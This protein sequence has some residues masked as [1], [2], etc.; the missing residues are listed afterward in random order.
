MAMDVCVCESIFTYAPTSCCTE[1][2]RANQL[3]N[4]CLHCSSKEVANLAV[5]KGP[6]NQRSIKGSSANLIQN[7]DVAA[8]LMKIKLIPKKDEKMEMQVIYYA[9][10]DNMMKS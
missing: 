9:T 4:A 6:L 8:L 1:V 5:T 10:T 7:N 2:S 3:L